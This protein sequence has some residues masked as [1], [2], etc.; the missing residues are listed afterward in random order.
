MILGFRRYLDEISA[1]LE[2]YTASYGDR[3]PTFQDNDWSHFQESRVREEP[4]RWDWHVV[5]KRQ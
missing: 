5:P 3:L 2:Y 1:L 4:W